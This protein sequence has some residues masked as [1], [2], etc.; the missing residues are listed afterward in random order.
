MADTLFAS[1]GDRRVIWA[2]GR[3]CWQGVWAVDLR[4][5]QSGAALSGRVTVKIGGR[6]L[7]GT[8]DPL[9]EGSFA[10]ARELRVLGGAGGWGKE[11]PPRS[12][13]NDAGV[14]VSDVL[15][16]AA[17]EAGET[18]VIGAGVEARL[19]ADFV[20]ERGP[21][22][23]SF[24]AAAP[25]ALWWVDTAGVT[26]VA[27]SR[28]TA[29]LARG[30]D[31]EVLDVDLVK[32]SAELAGDPGAVPLGVIL[33]DQRLTA[34]LV[35]RELAI[36]LDEDALRMWAYSRSDGPGGQVLDPL[37]DLMRRVRDERLPGVYRYRVV[38]MSGDRVKL[39]AVT[40]GRW[41]DVLPCRVGA[42]IA[43]GWASPAL[44]S[45]VKVAFEDEDRTLPFIVSCTPKGQPGHVPTIAALD[46]EEVQLGGGG[47]AVHRVGDAGKGPVITAAGPVITFTNPDGST[48]ILTDSNGSSWVLSGTAAPPGQTLTEATE[49]SETVNS[50]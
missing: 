15:Q 43:G 39:Q 27:T 8:V 29:E 28:P 24:A 32:V 49:G 41:P 3:L 35:V 34:P 11:L 31:V 30:A 40:K 9:H 14:K 23:A 2:D 44:G 26:Q 17:A 12:W 38:S 13:H 5:D 1:V 16:A 25:A 45:I 36:Q 10:D 7:S 18:L 46:G 33:R 22:S 20:R 4:L 37:I 48:V 21:A 42:G 6:T 47:P 50:G 19:G